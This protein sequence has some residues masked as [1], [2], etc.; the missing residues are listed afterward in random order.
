LSKTIAFLCFQSAQ[1]NHRFEGFYECVLEEI[2]DNKYASKTVQVKCDKYFWLEGV[3]N[4]EESV[5]KECHILNKGSLTNNTLAIINT[6]SLGTKEIQ[7]EEIVF[8]FSENAGGLRIIISS[9]GEK[10]VQADRYKHPRPLKAAKNTKTE[11]DPSGGTIET[12]PHTTH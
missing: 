8:F 10:E 7:T 12:R 6:S 9:R 3:L 4:L 1:N 2:S 11:T 5:L